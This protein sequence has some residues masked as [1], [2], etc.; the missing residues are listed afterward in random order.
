MVLKLRNIWR[1]TGIEPLGSDLSEE[2]AGELAEID[3]SIPGPARD[4]KIRKQ[5]E[6]DH[7]RRE[8]DRDER[9]ADRKDDDEAAFMLEAWLASEE[10]RRTFEQ[11]SNDIADARRAALRAYDRALKHEEEAR[12]ALEEAQRNAIVL[13][14]GRRVY[15]TRDGKQLFTEDD[16]QITDSASLAEAH[17]NRATQPN[18]T[19]YEDFKDRRDS[20]AQAQRNADQLRTAL[21]TLDDLER[22]IKSGRLSREELAQAQREKQDIVNSLPADA[23]EE[24]ERLQAA[25]R[26]EQHGA[27]QAADPAFQ[28]AP[29]VNSHFREAGAIAAAPPPPE[30]AV[31]D[32]KPAR[33]PAYVAAPDFGQ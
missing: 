2:L 23:R 4:R 14:D 11:L 30:S 17:Q 19:T 32:Q 15:F 18:A 7:A 25:R 6:E 26:H 10:Y 20:H 1:L 9:S 21:E 27:H 33:T 12:K 31:P 22:R 13:A 5:R 28:S 16:R 24:Y 8:N 29:A 3:A